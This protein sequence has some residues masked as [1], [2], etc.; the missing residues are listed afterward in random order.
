MPA[1][2]QAR[3]RTATI[4][5]CIEP[6][7]S[8]ELHKLKGGLNSKNRE[9]ELQPKVLDKNEAGKDSVVYAVLGEGIYCHR[10]VRAGRSNSC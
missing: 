4:A 8:P 1:C 6:F 2:R 7:K 3:A 10:P 5:A 9:S